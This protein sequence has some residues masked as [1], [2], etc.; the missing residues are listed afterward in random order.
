MQEILLSLLRSMKLDA[1]KVL[2]VLFQDLARDKWSKM[3]RSKH[4]KETIYRGH[5]NVVH[6]G[7]VFADVITDVCPHQ[8]DNVVLVRDAQADQR[9]TI[10]FSL[11]FECL[12]RR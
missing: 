11:D 9:C 4:R 8:K 7:Y 1:E 10:H 3:T 2:E 6:I 12:L 5:F